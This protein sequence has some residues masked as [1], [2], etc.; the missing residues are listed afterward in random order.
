[1]DG[2]GGRGTSDSKLVGLKIRMSSGSDPV[3]G[4]GESLTAVRCLLADGG[5]SPTALPSRLPRSPNDLFAIKTV[6]GGVVDDEAEA[7]ATDVKKPR[8]LCSALDI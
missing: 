7:I 5:G 3:A 8:A 4:R 1:M 2:P 6:G